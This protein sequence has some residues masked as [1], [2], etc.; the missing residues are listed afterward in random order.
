[1]PSRRNAKADL[2]YLMSRSNVADIDNVYLSEIGWVYRHFKNDAK[3]EFWDELIVSGEVDPGDVPNVFGAAAPTF[4]NDMGGAGFEFISDDVQA[5]YAS[6]GGTGISIRTTQGQYIAG[7]DVTLNL[8]FPAEYDDM[9]FQWA[10][11]DAGDSF[12]AATSAT[13]E[14]TLSANAGARAI[15]CTVNSTKGSITSLVVEIDVNV[16]HAASVVVQLGTLTLTPTSPHA[17]NAGV[18][19]QL[20]AT[21]SGNVVDAVYYWDSLSSDV[22][23]SNRHIAN[24][25]VTISPGALGDTDYVIACTV[26]SPSVTTG[27]ALITEE[28]TITSTTQRIG[29]VSIGGPATATAAN[30]E[31]YTV[32]VNLDPTNPIT[33][34]N[35]YQYDWS[36]QDAVV[37]APG[38]TSTVEVTFGT[39]G[40]GRVLTCVVSHPSSDIAQTATISVDVS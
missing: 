21:I 19:V 7:E 8:V 16:A 23:F 17:A 25:V 4:L 3:T 2:G 22:S 33:D 15:T 37:T 20:G 39:P 6:T 29:T 31:N 9:T 38:N 10:S 32:T 5:P 34:T 14:L 30:P 11:D 28:L 18:P 12:S 24:P 36:G 35:A 40:I 1:M 26:E 27:D 13:T